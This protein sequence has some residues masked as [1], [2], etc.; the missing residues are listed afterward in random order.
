MAPFTRLHANGGVSGRNCAGVYEIEGTFD[1]LPAIE[2]SFEGTLELTQASQESGTLEGSIAILATLGDEIFNV[3]DDALASARVSPS[4][5]I[6][7]TA[8]NG[9][10]TWT[11][12]GTASGTSI[13]DGRHTL[14]DGDESVS[15][16]WRG[17][18]AGINSGHPDGAKSYRR[19]ALSIADAGA[20]RVRLTAEDQR[21]FLLA[22]ESA[23]VVRAAPDRHPRQPPC[24]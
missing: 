11:F 5:V 3:S 21:P 17:D 15:G 6:S 4:G 13:I 22:G 18:A 24:W 14:S 7:F 2:A 10:A 19:S 16:P 12:T 23:A 8:G 9:L 20:L 1:D